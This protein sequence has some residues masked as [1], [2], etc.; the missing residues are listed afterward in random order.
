MKNE[1]L[2]DRN[3]SPEFEVLEDPNKILSK[4]LR[5][6]STDTSLLSHPMV[7]RFGIPKGLIYVDE[8]TVEIND[9]TYTRPLLI[10]MFDEHLGI[11]Q[12]AVAQDQQ[13]I[14]FI[15]GGYAKGFASHGEMLKDKPIIL[16][17]SIEVF[18]RLTHTA[19]SV[20]LVV[21]PN[22]CKN[23]NSKGNKRNVK[24][25]ELVINQLTRA[26]YSKIYFPIRPEH[27]TYFDILEKNT[28]VKLVTQYQED[29][30]C[31]L[32]Q[33]DDVE[34]IE[35]FLDKAI[36]RLDQRE[37]LSQ[38]H[39]ARPM[40]WNDG[41]FQVLKSGIY[42][43]ESTS[44]GKIHKRF[45]SS[46]VLVKAKTRDQTSNNWGILLEWQDDNKV[47]HRQA[48]SM[49]LFQ[50]DGADLR[51]ELAYQGV[52]ISTERRA[53]NLFLDYLA[54]YPTDSRA[55][56]VD[57]VGWHDD[58]FVLPHRNFGE[59][60]SEPIVYQATKSI[61]N[62]YQIKGTLEQ[63]RSEVS[64]KIQEHSFLVFTLSV[65]FTG[66]L[67]SPLG[68]Q[69][70]GFHIKGGSSKGKTTALNVGS[71]V[72]GD[73]TRFYRTWR[74]T[75]N[76]LEVTA[77][78]HNDSFLVLDEIGEVTNPKELGVIVYMLANGIGKARM[79]KHITSRAQHK[80]KVVF[81]S[82]GE[83]SLKQMMEEQG[84]EA[85]LG[86]EIRLADIDIDASEFG[87][88]D[89]INFAESAAHQATKI[90]NNLNCNYGVAGHQ[91]LEY[92]TADKDA[93]LIT[94]NR[95]LDEYRELLSAANTQ[96]HIVRVANSFALVAVAGELA[97]H[98]GIT[99][100]PKGTAIKSIQKVFN[101]WRD[102]FE[103]VHDSEERK[104]LAH[105]KAFFEANGASLFESMTPDPSNSSKVVNRS[106]Y[107]RIV[108][109][110][111]YFLVYPGQLRKIIGNKFSFNK[112]T[113]VLKD[114]GW[115]E[116]SN[117]NESSRSER[118]PDSKTTT[119]MYVFN[120]KMW[121]FY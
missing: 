72:W 76:A 116:L 16:T 22:M 4:C 1:N 114:Y 64:Q 39:L 66:Q 30:Q 52:T 110:E 31:E 45:I 87:I 27:K 106:G 11:I 42:Y 107:W 117:S 85:K 18:F 70:G 48:L 86:Q 83:K 88:F 93:I 65:A 35:H 73:P 101:Q 79:T 41:N 91:W 68:Q 120:E 24:Q 58:V 26:G 74:A 94:A 34:D 37:K 8:S 77:L 56:C 32:S 3:S 90:N 25:I 19:Y 109:G 36:K 9:I 51:K 38:G 84:Q 6:E 43:V 23:D 61:D 99:G 78:M 82:S 62:R 75:G 89:C 53:R 47:R 7:Q 55:L 44:E 20:V 40:K 50:T 21:T 12:C 81:L 104:I 113:S 119:R 60:L 105:V 54:N 63:W 33:Y 103:Q 102:V 67:L 96:G 115:L 49:E 100:W 2:E 59:N 97:T 15:P 10:P 13:L 69:G 5:Y 111:K 17:D 57:S 98:A 108:N 46:P 14:Q 71:S 121:E 28:D 80:W 118:V 95:L 29:I 112:V 92:L